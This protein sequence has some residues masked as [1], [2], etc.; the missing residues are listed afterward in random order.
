S[1]V[2][3]DKLRKLKG[4]LKDFTMSVLCGNI[5]QIEEIAKLSNIHFKL[6]KR[7]IPGPYVFL[8]PA[9]KHIEKQINMK[10][11][12]I[13]IRISS[14][15]IPQAILSVH[16]TP[17]FVI[18]ASRQMTN[19]DWWNESFATE[20]LFEYGWELEDISGLDMIIDTGESLHRE[21]STVIDLREDEITILRQGAG[22][23]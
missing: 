8:L 23:L 1:K 20:N 18:T 7:L 2:G 13:G 11:V 4:G 22:T 15:P 21:L 5:K 3:I 6:I 14:H 10:R 17:L 12:E 16:D 19:K 9:K